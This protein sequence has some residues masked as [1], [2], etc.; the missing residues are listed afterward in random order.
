MPDHK[1][2]ELP[3]SK[4]IRAVFLDIDGTLFS[5]TQQCIPQSALKALS[6]L[7]RKGIL[8]Y[9]ATG[10][11]LPEMRELKLDQ[12]DVDGM[13]LLNGMLCMD[14]EG[15]TVFDHPLD[16]QKS[17]ILLELFENGPFPMIL[18]E[19]ERMYINRITEGVIE[20]AE[21]IH[22][23]PPEIDVWSKNPVYMA[24]AYG[25]QDF[26][27]QLAESLDGF[28]VTSWDAFGV[29]IVCADHG[30][31]AAVGELMELKGLDVSQAAAFGD[32]ENDIE[33]LRA[34]GLGIAMGNSGESVR[35]AA[36]YTA[37]H[38]DEDGLLKALLDLKILNPEDL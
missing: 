3:E 33:M 38:I 22:T 27:R 24:V 6:A 10:R 1:L 35:K 5:H 16:T 17:R 25:D 13:I 4:D 18:V 30:K 20:A 2:S 14:H 29:D 31:A 8:T 12:L 7:R 23:Q 32:G 37:D 36:D 21:A 34:V 11:S 26:Q 9:I 19:K 15:R 28:D